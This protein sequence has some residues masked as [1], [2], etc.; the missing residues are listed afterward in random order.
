MKA[1]DLLPPDHYGGTPGQNWGKIRGMRVKPLLFFAIVASAAAFF[2]FRYG[3]PGI[4][5]IGEP[6]PDVVLK[7]EN[8]QTTKLSDY[9]GQVVFLNFWATWCLPCVKEMP[10]MQAVNVAFQDRK[11]KMVAVSVDL[12][13]DKVN[14]FYK[15]YQLELPTFLDPGHQVSNAFKVYK[16]PETFIID[17]NGHVV[18]HRIGEE[19][20]ASPQNMAYLDTL[21]RQAEGTD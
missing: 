4:I 11:F 13:W 1:A 14:N 2:M 9:R 19:R 3:N 18:K 8:G 17:A 16:F 12:N 15:Q 21:V 7:A 5:S 10:E 6:A 20:W